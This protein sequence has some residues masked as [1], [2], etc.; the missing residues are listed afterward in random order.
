MMLDHV[1]DTERAKRV[2]N[3]VAAVVSEGRIQAYDMKK[4][5][6]GPEVIARGA[7]STTQLTDAIIAAL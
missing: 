1:G 3:A 2:R 6:G 4:L 5:A 7:A